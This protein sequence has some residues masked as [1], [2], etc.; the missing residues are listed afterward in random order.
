MHLQQHLT[1]KTLFFQLC[2][3]LDHGKLDHIRSSTLNGRIDRI[4]LC[5]AA[6]CKVGGINIPQ[7]ALSSHQCFNV[8]MFAGIVY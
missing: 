4:S 2:M 6:H 3:Y 5:K 7:P 1:F 8:T